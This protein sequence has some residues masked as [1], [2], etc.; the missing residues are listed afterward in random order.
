MQNI[1]DEREAIILNP[2]LLQAYDYILR[3]SI[4]CNSFSCVGNSS[5]TTYLFHTEKLLGSAQV[6]EGTYTLL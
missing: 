4:L 6:G 5:L 1:N 3:C 2:Y